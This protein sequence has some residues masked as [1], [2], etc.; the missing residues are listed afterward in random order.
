MSEVG[1]NLFINSG[2]PPTVK[3]EIAL[4]CYLNHPDSVRSVFCFAQIAIRSPPFP[5]SARR[6]LSGFVAR[7]SNRSDFVIAAGHS[8]QSGLIPVPRCINMISS[9]AEAAAVSPYLGEGRGIMG[10][11]RIFNRRRFIFFSA[12]RGGFFPPCGTYYGVD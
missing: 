10:Q 5:R 9:S 12:A 11:F 2:R 8:S 1:R 4:S 6:I 7:R 3:R